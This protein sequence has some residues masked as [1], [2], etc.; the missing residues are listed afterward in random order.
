MRRALLTSVR[1]L[2]APA[3]VAAGGRGVASAGTA[4]T[5]NKPSGLL[6]GHLMV[7][8]LMSNNASATYTA[9]DGSWN[10]VSGSPES[11]I[12]CASFWK[13]ADSA[14]AAAASFAFVRGTNTA[15]AGTIIMGVYSGAT[16][17]SVVEH[18][19][20]S[21]TSIG[22]VGITAPQN[23]TRLVHIVSKVT[24]TAGAY[25]SPPPGSATERKNE[26]TASTLI[27]YA[28]A[29]ELVAAGATGTKTW[30]YTG[31]SA[32]RGGLLAVVA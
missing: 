3:Y 21:G 16:S 27:N 25:Q 24:G 15:G 19:S 12:G 26:Q 10:H 11:A 20:A 32:S 29:D 4:F 13:I 7:A 9:P 1:S 28:L 18:T 14:D 17:V 2:A 31:S 8:M 6:A 22:L 30:T 23:D 5:I